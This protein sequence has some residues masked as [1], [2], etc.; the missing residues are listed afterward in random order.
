MVEG[1]G[2]ITGVEVDRACKE[3]AQ[4][5]AGDESGI[6]GEYIHGLGERAKRSLRDELNFIF[7]GDDSKVFMSINSHQGMIKRSVGYHAPRK[8]KL[9]LFKSLARPILEYSSQVWS[10]STKRDINLIESVQSDEIKI[11]DNTRIL[12]SSNN[13][14]L[15]FEHNEKIV[16]KKETRYLGMKIVRG[17][18]GGIRSLTERVEMCHRVAGLVKF[19]TKRSGSRFLIGREGWK[20]G[21]VSRIMYG[22]GALV[23]KVKERNRLEKEQTAFGTWLWKEEAWWRMWE[24]EYV[25]E[26]GLK[27]DWWRAVNRIAMDYNL[28]GVYYMLKYRR[29]S[30]EGKRLA[31]TPDGWVE[32]MAKEKVERKVKQR[33]L[34]KWRGNLKG[35]ERTRRY[36]EERK[37][38]RMERYADGGSGARVRMMVMQSAGEGKCK[39]GVEIRANG[40]AAGKV[41]QDKVSWFMPMYCYQMLKS[42]N[43]TRQ[44]SQTPPKPVAYK[45]R[46]FYHSTSVNELY[47]ET[48]RQIIP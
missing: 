47:L 3:I 29:L 37:D 2:N 48:L 32:E 35:T 13:G 15:L 16:E 38:M 11:L 43:C 4:G 39:C 46:H 19:A 36:A 18:Q 22:G 41:I 26:M 45:M 5:K 17:V 1:N 33:E 30:A 21:V 23:W 8:V 6:F 7:D 42:F 14:L 9:Q 44:S 40:V 10:P 25:L 12:R 24:E 28:D 20:S 34:E 27:S 31:R